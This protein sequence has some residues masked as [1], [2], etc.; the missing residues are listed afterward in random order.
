M[1]RFHHPLVGDLVL[2][3]DSLPLPADPGLSVATYSADPG[4]P[5]EAALGELARWAATRQQLASTRSRE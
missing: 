2:T 1:K 5:A 3:W 4:S